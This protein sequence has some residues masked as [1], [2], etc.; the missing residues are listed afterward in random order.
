LPVEYGMPTEGATPIGPAAQSPE[1]DAFAGLPSTEGQAQATDQVSAPDKVNTAITFALTMARALHQFGTPTDRLEQIMTAVAHCLG[2]N[3]HFFVIPTGIFASFG[4]PEEQRTALIRVEPSSV[5]LEKMSLL[6]D[7]TDRV[8]RTELSPAEGI[9]RVHEI[10]AAASCY[11]S[12]VTVLAYGLASGT[13]S[14]LFGGGWREAI[15][16]TVIGLLLGLLALAMQRSEDVQTLFEPAAALLVSVLAIIAARVLAPVS[17]TNL[18]ISGLFW[19]FPGL[20]LT[21]GIRELATRNLVSGTAQ[22]TAAGVVFLELGFGVALGIQLN[23]LLPVPSLMLD[24]I[25]LPPWTLW[26][27]LALSPAAIAVLLRARQRDIGW[28]TLA[29]IIGFGGARAGTLLLGPELGV[30]VGAFLVGIGSNIFSRAMNRPAA[31]PLVPG[32]LLLVPGSVGFTSISKFLYRDVL[33]GVESAFRMGLIAIALVSGLL[34]AT[35][36]VKPRQMG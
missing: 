19:L 1:Y 22:L 7:L 30:F 13:G 2:L 33:S 10:V 20:T 12:V 5:N 14:R 15:A 36:L 27:A 4:T 16:S 3:G 29:G 8:I 26:V 35:V 25:P 18:T 21:L 6:D 17:I 23:R 28:I 32:M 24:P 31:I 34:V 11:G 9:L